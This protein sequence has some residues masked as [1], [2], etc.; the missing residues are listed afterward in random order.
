MTTQEQRDH[1][2]NHFGKNFESLARCSWKVGNCLESGYRLFRSSSGIV[3]EEDVAIA[4]HLD[5]GQ[6]M[7]VKRL[8]HRDILVEYEND[9][10]G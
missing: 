5:Y 6:T 3:T 2:H 4:K 10:S 1:A 7:I 8:G 9:S